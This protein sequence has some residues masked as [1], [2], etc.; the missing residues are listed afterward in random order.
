[1]FSPIDRRS[2]AMYR[3]CISDVSAIIVDDTAITVKIPIEIY[4]RTNFRRS[5]PIISEESAII[6]VL[7]AMIGD[8]IGRKEVLDV[9]SKTSLRFFHLICIFFIAD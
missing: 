8:Q 2:S 1:M 4:V 3:R 6:G 7:S 5:S 9:T